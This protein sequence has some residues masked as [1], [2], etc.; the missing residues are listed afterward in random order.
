MPNRIAAITGASAGLGVVFARQLAARG[1]DLLLIARRRDRMEQLAEELSRAHGIH[2][3]ICAA[4]LAAEEGIAAVA[5]RLAVEPRLH[6]L[7]NNAGFGTRG[8]F[9]E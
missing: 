3:D 1:Y 9:H 5:A 8:R 2:A 6:L 4:D 7:V